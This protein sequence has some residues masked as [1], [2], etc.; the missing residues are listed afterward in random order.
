MG[1]RNAVYRIEGNDKGALLCLDEDLHDQTI[2]SLKAHGDQQL[3]V[4][5]SALD[6]TKKFELHN[7]FKGAGRGALKLLKR[8]ARFERGVVS[9]R[10]EGSEGVVVVAP[11]RQLAESRA[12]ALQ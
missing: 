8:P 7:A 5:K 1:T 11:E 6:T 2:E 4:A 3:I 10:R 12:A 9:Q